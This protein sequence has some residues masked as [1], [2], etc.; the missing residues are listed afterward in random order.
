[1]MLDS[2]K[3]ASVIVTL[4]LKFFYPNTSLRKL[5]L[6]YVNFVCKL[7]K[8]KNLRAGKTFLQKFIKGY[9][10][11]K[12]ILCHKVVCDVQLMNLFI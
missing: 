1:M 11:Y 12:T 6:T 10:C 5:M 8:A 4:K 7:R 3:K 2:W 9:L